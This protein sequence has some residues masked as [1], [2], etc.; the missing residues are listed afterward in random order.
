M[1]IIAFCICCRN[2]GEQAI[3][4]G[5]WIE[6]MPSSPQYIQGISFNEDGRASSIGM[7]TL[8]YEK[9]ETENN[10]LI[11]D[12]KSIGNGRTIEFSDTLDII[13]LSSDSLT[14]GKHGMYERRYYRPGNGPVLSETYKG[15]L[16]AASCPGIEY[17]VTVFHFKNNGDG[18]FHAALKYLEAEEGKDV[19][20]DICG[21]QYTLKGH[22]QDPN[23]VVLQ[24]ISYDGTTIMN[25]QKFGD[26]IEMLDQN[27]RPIKSELNYTLKLQ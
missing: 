21:R 20:Y 16:P 10:K 19:T 5:D 3:L 11:L 9:W 13:M 1:T 12:G 27:I 24:L 26:R 22:E 6:E 2:A 7:A 14:V 15:I 17:T 18:V 8:L 4:D 25:F 23:A